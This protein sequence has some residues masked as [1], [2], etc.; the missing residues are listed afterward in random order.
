M[1]RKTIKSLQRLVDTLQH[2]IYQ[3]YPQARVLAEVDYQDLQDFC[4]G[5]NA[6]C[7]ALDR[8]YKIISLDSLREFLD[9]N[10]VSERVYVIQSFDCDNFSFKTFVDFKH[11][12]PLGAFGIVIGRSVRGEMH[13]WNFF[14]RYDGA[15]RP[16]IMF[17]EPQTCE[18]FEPTTE[19]VFTVI[20]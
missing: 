4:K 19:Q 14:L 8:P 6:E 5:M 1:R 16:H 7:I 13:A 9:I 15:G 12:S 3:L 2:F 11:W 10:Q 17:V 20:I 18:I